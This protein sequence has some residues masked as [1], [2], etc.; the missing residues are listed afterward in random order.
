MGLGGL[1][2]ALSLVLIVV[3]V[4]GGAFFLVKYPKG[5]E[6]SISKHQKP[7]WKPAWLSPAPG[8]GIKQRTNV[9]LTSLGHVLP[10]CSLTGPYWVDPGKGQDAG[11]STRL[12]LP[13]AKAVLGT[14][15]SAHSR[16][17]L[18]VRRD[19]TPALQHL[20]SGGGE[21]GVLCALV[22]VLAA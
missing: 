7:G 12:L 11:L 1:D 17:R 10:P 15:S 6:L 18:C 13:E 14:Q 16:L 5:G 9:S 21:R 2:S 3:S 19:E 4:C 20:G 22:C 8:P